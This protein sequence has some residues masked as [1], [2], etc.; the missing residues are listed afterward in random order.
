[1]K[2]RRLSGWLRHTSAKIPIEVR[3]PKDPM[4]FNSCDLGLACGKKVETPNVPRDLAARRHRPLAT[5]TIVT[6]D[7]LPESLMPAQHTAMKIAKQCVQIFYRVGSQP[8]STPCV[9]PI[10]NLLL[11]KGLPL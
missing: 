9:R 2:G 4:P 10:G 6:E 7:S 11:K 1:M 5:F 8:V 3:H